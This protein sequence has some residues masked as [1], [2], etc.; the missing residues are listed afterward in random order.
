MGNMSYCRFENTLSDLK[1]CANH[2]E[3]DDLSETEQEARTRL[4]K[5]CKEIL[6]DQMYD[7]I[8]PDEQLDDDHAG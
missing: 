1:D 6:T 3:D 2:I 4:L 8:S 5:L 7:V